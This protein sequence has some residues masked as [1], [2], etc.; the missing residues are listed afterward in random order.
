[1]S[2]RRFTAQYLQPPDRKDSTAQYGGRL[3]PALS[4]DALVRAGDDLG[5]HFDADLPGRFQVENELEFGWHLDWQLAGACTAPEYIVV[6]GRIAYES[7]V[8]RRDA[9]RIDGGQQ[10]G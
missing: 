1:M 10:A 2:S 9:G 8:S 6:V 7:T 3:L 5:G 4:L